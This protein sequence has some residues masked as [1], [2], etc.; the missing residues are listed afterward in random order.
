MKS[1]LTYSKIIALTLLA[2]LFFNIVIIQD[3]F[4]DDNN[5]R[6]ISRFSM[7]PMREKIILN[8]GETYTS[9]FSIHAADT[10]TQPFY[11]KV[12]NQPYYRSEDNQV[13]FEE[14]SN[15]SQIANWTTINSPMNGSLEPG[16]STSISFT[17]HVPED[18]PAGGQYMTITVGS[19]SKEI[20]ENGGVNIQESIA[21]GYTVYAEIAGTTIR[22][23]EIVS[24]NVPSF[25]FSGNITG[26][27]AIKNTGNVHGDAKYAL[28]VFPLFSSEEIY[29]NEENPDIHLILPDR[30]LYSETTWKN[31]P[32]LGIF[33]VIYTVEFE[34]VTTQ[35]KKLIIKCPIWLLALII[36][37][38][39][40]LIA[41]FIFITRSRHKRPRSTTKLGFSAK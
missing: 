32:A 14:H 30:T 9:S 17:I 23:G 4:A 28:Q 1:I 21:I 11:Y 15:M 22:Q 26:S 19:D 16:E 31:T 5:V 24:A 33:N 41:R 6:S 36:F 20:T 29:T 3:T 27:S 25:L 8:P 7:S 39:V 38:I 18:A 40:A 35:I 2:T 10:I 37:G 13:V 12:Y 34:G